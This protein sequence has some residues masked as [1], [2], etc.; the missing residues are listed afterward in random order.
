M[1]IPGDMIACLVGHEGVKRLHTVFL[2][3]LDVEER[4]IDRYVVET[5]V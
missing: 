5:R 1:Y 3:L 2:Y 4:V